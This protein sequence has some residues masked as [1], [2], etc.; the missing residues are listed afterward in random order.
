MDYKTKKT[1]NYSQV[2]HSK[3]IIFGILPSDGKQLFSQYNLFDSQMFIKYLEQVRK[4][5]KKFVKF[6]DRDVKFVD[7]AQLRSTV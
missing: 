2:V 6:V 5:F 1:N 4:K 7:R 3:T